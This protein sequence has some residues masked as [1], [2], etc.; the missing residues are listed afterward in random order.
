MSNIFCMNCDAEM[1]TIPVLIVSLVNGVRYI[2]SY[3]KVLKHQFPSKE[4][5]IWQLKQ[6]YVISIKRK[7]AGREKSV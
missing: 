6:V 5:I 1:A 4:I 2:T 7:I 3:P